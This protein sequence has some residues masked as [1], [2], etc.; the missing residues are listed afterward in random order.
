MGHFDQIPATFEGTRNL[1]RKQVGR[2]V[3]EVDLYQRIRHLYTVQGRS[4]R[5]IAR[6]LGISR[7]TVQKYCQ[8]GALP[9]STHASA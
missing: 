9:E 3:I 2:I 6:E 7:T 4:Q 8:G 5:S 1:G